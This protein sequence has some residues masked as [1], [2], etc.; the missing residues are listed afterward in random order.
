MEVFKHAAVNE[1]KDKLASVSHRAEVSMAKA[2]VVMTMVSVWK[3][4]QKAV[5]YSMPI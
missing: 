1:S 3:A 5:S 4:Y 2:Q